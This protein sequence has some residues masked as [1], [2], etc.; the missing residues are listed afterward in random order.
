M[1]DRAAVASAVVAEAPALVPPQA[2]VE[3]LL[4][5]QA[6][7]VLLLPSPQAPVDLPLLPVQPPV[8]AELRVRARR[9]VAAVVSEVSVEV[10]RLS[11]LS[12]QSCSA[13]MAR[14]TTT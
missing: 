2:A 4:L 1:A 14:S 11:L 13:A 9:P 8:V 3:P 10:E 12:R 7:A 5:E 6:V